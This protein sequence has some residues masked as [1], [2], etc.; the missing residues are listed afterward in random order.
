MPKGIYTAKGEFIPFAEP[1]YRA[2][3]GEIAT[4]AAVGQM[5]LGGFAAWLPDPD[6]VL[7]KKGDD[8]RILEDLSADDQVTTA[9]QARKLRVLNRADY[10]FHPGVLPGQEATKPAE[11]LTEA[12]TRDLEQIR[13]RDVFSAILDAPFYGCTFIE[14]MWQ[15]EGGRYRL[16]DLVAKPREWF[17]FDKERRP[18]LK[19]SGGAEIKPLPREKFLVTRHFPTYT[20]PYGLRLL[21][22]CLWPV[23]FKR[24]G[25]KFF[26]T[27]LERYGQ[28]WVLGKAPQSASAKEKEAMAADLARMVQDAVAVVPS[29]AEV[30]LVESKGSAGA[31]FE[32]YLKRWDKAIFKIIMGQTLTSEMDGQGSRAAAQVHQDVAEGM[33]ESDQFMVADT[34]NLLAMIYRDLNAPGVAAPVFAFHEPEDYDAQADLDTKLH[35]MGVRFRQAHFERR[36]GLQPEEFYLLKEEGGETA[37]DADQDG[38]GFAEGQP[39]HQDLL[40]QLVEAM[41]P[42]AAKRNAAF[43]NQLLELIQR[44]ESYQDIQLLLAEHLG[45]EMGQ[46][47][48]EDLLADLLTAAQL[49]GRAAVRDEADA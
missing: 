8:A 42:E 48:Q 18:A 21:S 26:T 22:R 46:D 5:D 13:L 33:A 12:L 43:V 36:Y 49:M 37:G 3:L 40:D 11:D 4:P 39:D 6:P 1:G 34:L 41:L 45:R 10:D 31:Q 28:P 24:G 30:S 23:A 20:N 19:P 32:L 25:I 17:V 2:L 9:M 16:A 44:A 35:E 14:I 47:Q 27:F 7:R 15:A 38:G 29:G